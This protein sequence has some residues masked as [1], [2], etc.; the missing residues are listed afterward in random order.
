M[1]SYLILSLWL[2][3]ATMFMGSFKEAISRWIIAASFFPRN[4]CFS[5]IFIYI[6][7]NC[8]NILTCAGQVGWVPY[9]LCDPL[10]LKLSNAGKALCLLFLHKFCSAYF[11]FPDNLIR[12][13]CFIF[14]FLDVTYSFSSCNIFQEQSQN[15]S[16]IYRT[17]ALNLK[18]VFLAWHWLL[19]PVFPT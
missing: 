16:W 17:L 10:E 1:F 19:S 5:I 2:S 3:I 9:P 6:L 8:L 4:M 12:V 13:F 15:W 14:K 11:C 18:T 7:S